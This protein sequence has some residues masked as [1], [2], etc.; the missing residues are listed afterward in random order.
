MGALKATGYFLPFLGIVEILGGVLF[1]ANRFLPL[2]LVI[3]A[4]VVVNILAVHT[5]LDARALPLAL[6]LT[7]LEL[8]LVWTRQEAFRPLFAARRYSANRLETNGRMRIGASR[9]V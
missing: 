6:T 9:K 1:L 5:F 3:T 2:A 4:P 7:A 8:Y